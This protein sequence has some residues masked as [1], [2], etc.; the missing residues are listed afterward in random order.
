MS[1]THGPVADGR[2]FGVRVWVLVSDVAPLRLYI[3]G[4]G[5]VLFSSH[6]CGACDT[7]NTDCV[8]GKLMQTKPRPKE[9]GVCDAEL[10]AR[11]TYTRA[12]SP[13]R[14]PKIPGRE[15]IVM[16]KHKY[17]MLASLEASLANIFSPTT[18]N[19]TSQVVSHHFHTSVSCP[20]AAVP[21]G[22]T[23][24]WWRALMGRDRLPAT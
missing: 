2:K 6:R 17:S 18:R 9:C 15:R 3:H 12:K 21:A 14:K 22:T 5:L 10:V 16:I 11:T 8:W 23:P 13:G 1:W 20:A 19:L 4:R 24:N 7:K